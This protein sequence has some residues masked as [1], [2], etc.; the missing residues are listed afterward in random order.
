MRGKRDERA[1]DGYEAGGTAGAGSAIPLTSHRSPLTGR[2]FSPLA[3]RASEFPWTSDVIYL[4]AAG[5]GPLPERTRR[6]IEEFAGLRAAPHRLS[7]KVLF[8]T[9]ADSRRLAATLINAEPD[10]IALAPNTSYG[11]NLAA[12]AL[13]LEPGDVVLVSDRE[14]PA[15][16]YPW[17]ALR[18]RGIAVE[19]APTTAQGWP[20]EAYLLQRVADPRVRVLAVSLTQFANGYTVDLAGL[21][22]V[23]RM[24]HTYL[25]VDAIQAVGQLPV[26]VH[27]T[28]VD[29]LACG[30]QKWLLSP[31]GSGFVYVRRD[32]IASL[33]PADVGWL[34]FEGTDDLSRLTRYDTTLRA[35]ARRYE[36]VT[37]PYQDF[38]GLNAS[39]G[40]L[41]EVGIETIRAYLRAVIQPVLAWAASA[42]VRLAS[43]TGPHGSAIVCVELPDA[44]AAYR[45]L[46]SAGI[47]ATVREGVV[48]LS[49][50]LY[51]TPAELERVVEVLDKVRGE[52]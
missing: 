44:A 7:E 6:V 33:P 40:L 21:S 43:P 22:R 24:T 18:D 46:K 9:L 23:T 15:N 10:E 37:L 31:W 4:N 29:L 14:F 49:P 32:L 11:L 52:K 38:T 45:A 19:L 34:A 50:H 12:R 13:P 20:D 30:G 51:N 36:L 41:L 8:G 39:L 47:F 25:V 3:L 1:A 5:I 16:V 2:P 42:G 28:P 48:R 35:D 27:Q 26:D 17:L